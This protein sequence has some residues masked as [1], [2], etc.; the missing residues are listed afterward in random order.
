MKAKTK[1][2]VQDIKASETIL[3]GVSAVE[4]VIEKYD[5][6][7]EDESKA[8][9]GQ[10]SKAL[11]WYTSSWDEKNYYRAA[12]QYV[13][14]AGLKS[15]LSAVENADFLDI[16][17]IGAIGRLIL[18]EQFVSPDHIEK[19]MV[20]LSSL[21]DKSPKKSV[22]VDTVTEKKTVQ[23]RIQDLANVHITEFEGAIDDLIV[24][25]EE[26]STQA[27]LTSN[28][29]SGPVAKKISDY[30]KPIL[31]ELKLIKTD[32]EIRE[33]YT[34]L[35]SAKIKKLIALVQSF[36][37]DSDQQKVS[38]T[39]RKPRKTKPKSP[40]KLVEKLKYLKEN[41]ELKLKSV[42]PTDIVGASEAWFYDVEKR[43]LTVYH[44]ADGGLSVKGTT[45]LNFDVNT[46]ETK[47]IRK[48]TSLKGVTG[49]RAMNNLWKSIKTKGSKPNGR[50][51]D[52]MIIMTAN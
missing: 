17:M 24:K 8:Y 40:A 43:K 25:G 39:V 1:K 9:Q 20:K 7:D 5:L 16:R 18:R 31:D 44:A 50:T 33:A 30:F 47:M 35:T 42:K 32:E 29:V 14:K 22:D 52:N 3:T 12:I 51:N 10:M 48:P 38:A 34:Y 28:E 4:P 2:P 27:Y 45:I 21:K 37:S 41:E 36:V 19:I 46:S 11:N 6:S 13:K 15:Y 49:K 23:D 26:F